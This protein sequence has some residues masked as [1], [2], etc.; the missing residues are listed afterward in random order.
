MPSSKPLPQDARQLAFAVL[1]RVRRG[2]FADVALSREFAKAAASGRDRA[3]ATELIYGSLRRQRTLDTLMTQLGKKTAQ[4]Q[5]PDLRTILHLGLYQLRYL[6]Q[7]P[8]SA[9]VDT[10]VDLAKR[11]GLSRLAPVVN[12]ILRQYGRLAAQGAVLQLPNHPVQRL[13]IQHSFPDWMVENFAQML[14]MEEVAALCDWLN[15]PP[16][17]DLRINTQ[18]T[19]LEAVE[20]AFQAQ[21]IPVERLPDLPQALRLSEHVGAIEQ[22]PGYG[23]GWWSVQDGSA[24][25]VAHLVD[26]QPGETVIDACA[27]PGG[28]ALHMA[29]LMGDRGRIL[30]CDRASSRVKKIAQNSYR[31]KLNAIEAHAVDSTHYPAFEA[32]GDRVLIDAPCSG[33]GT[34]HRH[35]DA[36]WR[37]S[38]AKV[39]ELTQLQQALLAHTATWVKPG[40]LLVYATCTLHPAENEQIVRRFLSAYPQWQIEPPPAPWVSLAESPGWIKRWPHRSDSDGFFIVRLRHLN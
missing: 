4:Q 20:A 9:A 16:T 3:L 39:T 24:Q 33:L 34:L 10:T 25:L 2:A 1:Q 30:A 22:V 18:V 8:A 17:I 5:P 15:R 19:T 13:G 28:K 12:G 38:P 27:A 35:A 23:E 31:L 37:Q 32:L 14:P 29:E 36:R 26:P 11:V 7:I 40:G 6:D 21:Q